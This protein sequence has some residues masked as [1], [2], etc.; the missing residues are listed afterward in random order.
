MSKIAYATYDAGVNP[1]FIKEYSIALDKIS[2]ILLLDNN[3][4]KTTF[5]MA[6]RANNIDMVLFEMLAKYLGVEECF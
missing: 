2:M 1:I 3:N 4:V 6:L 5:K